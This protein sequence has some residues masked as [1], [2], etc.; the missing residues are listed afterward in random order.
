VAAA[1]D[2][3]TYDWD[4]WATSLTPFLGGLTPQEQALLARG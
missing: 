1:I 4:A 3:G 2:E